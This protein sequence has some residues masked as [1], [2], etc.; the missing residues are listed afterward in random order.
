MKK[1]QFLAV[2][3]LLMTF[4]CSNEDLINSE[5]DL[6]VLEENSLAVNS[7]ER[8]GN[9]GGEV[10]GI[11]FVSNSIEN[12]IFI[13]GSCL[14]SPYPPERKLLKD[15]IFSGTIEGYGKINPKISEYEIV[16][17][18]LIPNDGIN[19]ER[20]IE[21]NMYKLTIEGRISLSI[22]EYCSIHIVGNVYPI[23]YSEYTGGEHAWIDFDGG[24]FGGFGTITSGVGKL[25]GLD[26]KI[27][28]VYGSIFTSGVN[29]FKNGKIY[30]N[31]TDQF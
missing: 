3:A 25:S 7:G 24:E 4:G 5:Q 22:K 18:E 27:L 1:I 31:I 14:I 29:D 19:P 11:N 9:P 30:L 15:G 17:C 28:L 23:N 10:N 13:D 26:N 16:N 12:G 21:E 6:V 2:M 20:Y 8:R